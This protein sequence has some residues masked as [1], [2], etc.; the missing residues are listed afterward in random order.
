MSTG[1]VSGAATVREP[2]AVDGDAG[3]AVRA[4]GG[5]AGGVNTRGG[6]R[7]SPGSV[8]VNCE[9]VAVTANAMNSA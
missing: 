2:V 7:R 5:D 8:A 6:T 1:V 3:C 4:G 9:R